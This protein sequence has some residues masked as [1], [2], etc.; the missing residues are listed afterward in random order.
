VKRSWITPWRARRRGPA[1]AASAELVC[2]EAVELVTAYLDDAL[3]PAA[4]AALERHLAGCPHCGEYFAQIRLVRSTAARVEPADL[5]PEARSD[6][7]ALYQRWRDD[8]GD[9]AV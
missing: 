1:D 2:R 5:A 8:Q 9:A 3:E 4:R 7:M 6:L